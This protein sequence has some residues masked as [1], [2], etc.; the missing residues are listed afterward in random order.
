MLAPAFPPLAGV[1][2]VHAPRRTAEMLGVRVQASARPPRR[3]PARSRRSHP[4]IS[5]NMARAHFYS[6]YTTRNLGPAV[7]GART[8][9]VCPLDGPWTVKGAPQL[10]FAHVYERLKTP[11][12]RWIFREAPLK[13]AHLNFGVFKQS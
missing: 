6:C 5:L 13:N 2:Q 11:K 1:A 10:K 9:G 7:A 8:H 4:V 12:T 3:D